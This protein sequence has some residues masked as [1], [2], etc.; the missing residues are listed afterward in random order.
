MFKV[1]YFEHLLGKADARSIFA[2][3]L[4]IFSPFGEGSMVSPP[5]R[6]RFILY[7]SAALYHAS[8]QLN[9]HIATCNLSARWCFSDQ[10]NVNLTG[11]AN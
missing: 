9:T 11:D 3:L 5:A 7:G 4:L 8:P 1:I 6:R 10:V 2:L